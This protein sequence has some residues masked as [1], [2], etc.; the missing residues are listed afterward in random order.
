MSNDASNV[1]NTGVDMVVGSRIKMNPGMDYIHANNA[2]LQYVRCAW[3]MVDIRVTEGI[4]SL[5]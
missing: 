5:I 3:K 1:E 2:I 4:S